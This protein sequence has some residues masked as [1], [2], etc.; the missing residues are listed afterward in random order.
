M[1]SAAMS[2]GKTQISEIP[3]ACREGNWFAV[4]TRTHHEKRVAEQLTNRG[5]ESF[6]PL[7][8]AVH[9]WT[10][11]RKVD[12]ELPLFPNYLFVNI[13]PEQRLRTLEVGGVLSLVSKGNRPA[14]LPNAEIER[15]RSG[16]RS[17][18]YEPCPY[19]T[20]GTRVRIA[21]GP[22]AGTEGIVLRQ[23]SG[24]RFVLTVNLIMQS[25]AIEVDGDELELS[26]SPAYA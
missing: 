22:L 7:Y 21:A 25:V 15:L 1:E 24:L 16:L 23:K 9:H 19:L 10:H 12:L 13:T 20:A 18:K 6:L 3:M 14:A 11:N 26:A 5:I 2:E 17:R 8:H 4:F